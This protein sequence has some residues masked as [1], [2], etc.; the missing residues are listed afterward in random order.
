MAE[1]TA[2]TGARFTVGIFTVEP[3]RMVEWTGA[4]YW[5][6]RVIVP[7]DVTNLTGFQTAALSNSFRFDESEVLEDSLK[8]VSSKIYYGIGFIF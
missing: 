5:G 6:Y 7:D 4:K 1:T 3:V 8:L 2:V